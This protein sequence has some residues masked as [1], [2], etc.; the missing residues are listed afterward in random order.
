MRPAILLVD[1]EERLR[2][3]VKLYLATEYAVDEAASGQEALDRWARRRYD[4]I[5]LD[6]ML[7]DVDGWEVCKQIRIPTARRPL[8]ADF[9]RSQPRHAAN[10]RADVPI[11]MLTARAEVEDRVLGLELGADDYVIKPFDPRE[12]VARVRALLRRSEG[13]GSDRI[14]PAP[15]LSIDIEGRRVHH[16]GEEVALT[17]KEFDLLAFLARHPGQVLTRDVLL[18][19]VW[20]HEFAGETRTVDTH[21][22]NLRDKL[23][24]G[25]SEHQWIVTVWGIGYRFELPRVEIARDAL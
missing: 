19:K 14:E 18:D 2:R 15:G 5:I 13:H 4:L 1:D 22:K 17:P 8:G 9:G 21:V 25:R 7:P 16:H 24:L 23:G 20:G 10:G 11:L 6:L 3:L 12:L